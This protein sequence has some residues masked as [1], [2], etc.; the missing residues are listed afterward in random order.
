MSCSERGVVRGALAVVACMVAVPSAARADKAAAEVAFAEA[1][2]L[3]AAGKVAEACPKFELSHNQD[4]QLGTLLNLADCHEQVGKLASAWA[5][6][7]AA[8]ELARNRGDTREAFAR[9]RSERLAS[10]ISRVVLTPRGDAADLRV[11][12]D[13][14]D[15]TALL[16][17]AI[18][19]DPGDHV[20]ATQRAGEDEVTRTIRVRGEGKQLELT[21][22][23]DPPRRGDGDDSSDED[24]AASAST[25][26]TRRIAGL[27]VA[28][29]GLV[30]AAIGGYFGKR[31]FDRWDDSRQFCDQANRCD[32]E[33]GRL[34][35]EARSSAM[36]AN[37][38]VGVGIAALA[39]GAIVYFTA[40]RRA[41]KESRT[42]VTAHPVVTP[43][44]AGGA[45]I[46]HF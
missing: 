16:G 31:A 35:D 25:G 34:V 36:A 7:R 44:L 38:L 29:S 28:G 24:A 32:A 22:P 15:V 40:P 23:F 13:D 17:V 45:L 21:V 10:R 43:S 8:M 1:K 9:E 3:I 39:A 33:G 20:I 11:K 42:A 46:V 37:V 14:R 12:L 6:F 27:G 41:A 26:R 19:V 18:P 5:E 30:V 4:P 2:R